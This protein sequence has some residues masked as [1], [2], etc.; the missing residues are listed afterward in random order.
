MGLGLMI[1]SDQA[2]DHRAASVEG[3]ATSRAAQL[4]LGLPGF[5]VLAVGE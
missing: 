2:T 3:E 1:Q 4:V 5:V